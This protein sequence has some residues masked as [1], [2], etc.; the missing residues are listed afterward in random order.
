M[1]F[2]HYPI[3]PRRII[4]H[5]MEKLSGGTTLDLQKYMERKK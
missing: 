3:A 1:S 5:I 2:C 4:L